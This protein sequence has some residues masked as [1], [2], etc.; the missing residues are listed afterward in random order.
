M[1][2]DADDTAREGARIAAGIVEPIRLLLKGHPP[3]VQGAAL[4][5]LLALFIAGHR[6]ELRAE[7]LAMSICTAIKL[8]P[9]IEHELGD[10]WEDAKK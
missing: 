9:V 3:D 1:T 2:A 8:I 5:Q 4:V 7:V 6:P 10:P